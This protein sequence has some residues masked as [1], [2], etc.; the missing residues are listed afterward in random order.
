MSKCPYCKKE[1]Y[2]IVRLMDETGEE[3]QVT[4]EVCQNKKCALYIDLSR[5][6]NWKV[7]YKP[8]EK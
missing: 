3:S 4:A 1:Q 2:T 7:K 5:L 8:K 6:K